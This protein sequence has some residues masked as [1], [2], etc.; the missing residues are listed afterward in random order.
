M[1]LKLNSNGEDV[2][3]LQIKLGLISDGVFGKNTELKVK[4][5]QTSNGLKADGI[6]G[7]ITWGKLFQ[8]KTTTQ[9]VVV[10]SSDIKLENIKSIIPAQVMLEI[11]SIITKYNLNKLKLA[12]FLSQCSH[13]SGGFK[14]V[15]ENL[16]YTKDRMLEI[17]KSDFD[18]NHDK[19]LS[20]NEKQKADLLKGSPQKIANFV[21]ANQNG[22]GNEASGDGWNF[23]G[24]GYIQ[25]TGRINYTEFDKT[26]NDDI[27]ANPDLVAT[28]YP[29]QSAAFFFTKNNLWSICN[30]GTS[31]ETIKKLTKRINGG[32]NGLD[33]R[34]A[35][36]NQIYKLL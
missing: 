14:V 5:W 13:E 4:E 28:K 27:L 10:N 18:T 34:I 11:P 24:R 26:V 12:H 17:F 23:R 36:F 8:D 20:I 25:L 3:K 30:E 21:Y 6:V 9:E 15:S 33:D 1:L 29:L 16:N 31:L 19:I 35:K 32:L 2:K 7:D 22:N